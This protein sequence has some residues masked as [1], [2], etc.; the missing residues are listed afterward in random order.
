MDTGKE[1]SFFSYWGG[2]LTRE[3]EREPPADP[4]LPHRLGVSGKAVKQREGLNRGR[5]EGE[6]SEG[7]WGGQEEGTGEWSPP[8]ALLPVALPYSWGTVPGALSVQQAN[9]PHC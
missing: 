9:T 1:K 4:P 5:R 6:G 2:S 7:Q 8:S 3:C